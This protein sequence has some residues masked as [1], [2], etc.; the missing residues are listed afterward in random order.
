M[1]KLQWWNETNV[2]YSK[3]HFHANCIKVCS[4]QPIERFVTRSTISVQPIKRLVTR[5][6]ISVQPIERLVTRSSISVQPTERLVTRSTVN[7]QPIER[8]VT[9]LMLVIRQS[10]PSFHHLQESSV[11]RVKLR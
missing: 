3:Q 7:V 10:C 1:N 2:F 11:V 6:T 8:S 5:S 4:V 9:R